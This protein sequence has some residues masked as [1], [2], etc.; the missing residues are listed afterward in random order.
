MSSIFSYIVCTSVSW[1]RRPFAHDMAAGPAA[2]IAIRDVK[3]ATPSVTRRRRRCDGG[4]V[5][6]IVI[7]TDQVG[8]KRSVRSHLGH[9]PAS[10]QRLQ[11]CVVDRLRV[12]TRWYLPGLFSCGA[13]LFS[14][15]I[16]S[17][18]WQDATAAESPRDSCRIWLPRLRVT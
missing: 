17:Q 16:F 7:R 8:C 2:A 5:C 4:S 3:Q 11:M 9:L 14:Q 12:S 15:V 10:R 1:C 6:A 18:R 13:G